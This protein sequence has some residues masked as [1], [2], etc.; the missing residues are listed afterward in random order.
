MD[1]SM[2]ARMAWAQKKADANSIGTGASRPDTADTSTDSSES[3]AE[4]ESYSHADVHTNEQYSGDE[5]Y[6]NIDVRDTDEDDDY[7]MDSIPDGAPLQQQPESEKSDESEEYS[8]EREEQAKS[9]ESIVKD[10]ESLVE[11]FFIAKTTNLNIERLI[12]YR[13]R[14]FHNNVP[15]SEL[16]EDISRVGIV[17]PLLVCQDENKS[18]HYEIISGNARKQIA[19]AQNW[20]K[21]PCMIADGTKAD[22]DILDWIAVLENHERFPHLFPSE[23]VR[24]ISIIRKNVDNIEQAAIEEWFNLTDKQV[25]D[26]TVLDNL[27]QSLLEM[28]DDGTITIEI[29]KKLTELSDDVQ[30]LITDAIKDNST[31]RITATNIEKIRGI[32]KPNIKVVTN[33]LQPAPPKSIK[34]SAELVEQYFPNRTDGEI[35]ALVEKAIKEYFTA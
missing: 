21:V 13:R 28:L 3:I 5:D 25:S 12:P 35:T 1:S 20:T 18:G 24:A 22:E 30:E 17:N 8:E 7:S 14:I 34:I 27:N 26:Y 16:A 10:I 9:A 2:I 33:L 32:A 6:I 23:A 11:Q 29:A 31:L 15:N 4:K 19:D